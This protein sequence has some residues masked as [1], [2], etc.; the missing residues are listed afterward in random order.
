[1]TTMIEDVFAQPAALSGLRKYYSSPGAIPA[2]AMRKLVRR[3]PPVV[4]FT[5]MG[6]SLFAAYPAQA[7]LTGL[8]IR[9]VVWE[10]AEL[11][12][13]HLRFLGPDTLLVAVSQSGETIEITRLLD[14]LPKQVGLLGVV[15]VEASTLARRSRLLLPM[16][17]GQQST[18]STKTYMCSVA[19]LM[20]LAV[21]IAGES[22]RAL[23]QALMRSIEAQERIL[24]DTEA[25]TG[26]TVEFFGRPQ[27]AA[28]MSRGPDL[29][30]V[31]QGALTLKEVVRM[32]AEAISAAQFRH[33]PI[34]I[35][36][37]DHRYVV[38]ARQCHRGPRTRTAK[39]L[40]NL[41]QDIRGHGGRV[42]L[43]TDLPVEAA[44]NMR[45]ISVEA[46]RLGLGTLVD[47]LHI[48]LL[49]H[50]LAL[51]AGLDPGKFWIADEVTREE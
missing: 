46:A 5:G 51:R 4:V 23:T 37:P 50:E 47:T 21:E 26:P 20:Y 24:D 12:H 16:M 1:M 10:T 44:P 49:A 27:Y 38:F 7:Y 11:L 13:H 6:S 3:W 8:G 45:L 29:A 2:R 9:A 17:A 30:S 33:G 31:Y 40:V 19:V 36:S 39:F 34:E 14:R 35:I 43:L 48:Q 32:G 42:L 25:T 15:N 22:P 18:V 41:A 28:L